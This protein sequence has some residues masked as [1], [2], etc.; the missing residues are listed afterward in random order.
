MKKSQ[1]F[2]LLLLMLLLS[3]NKIKN[4]IG[5]SN[6]YYDTVKLK[7]KQYLVFTKKDSINHGEAKYIKPIG[8]WET[9]LYLQ[10][11]LIISITYAGDSIKRVKYYY[12]YRPNTIDTLTLV[13]VL[14]ESKDNLKKIQKECYYIEDY[15][16]DTINYG[17][18]YEVEIIGNNGR[19]KDFGMKL[20]LGDID[21]NYHFIG[22]TASFSSDSN[23]LKYS[24]NDYKQGIN[25][26]T[27][28]LYY[29]KEGKDITGEALLKD[30]GLPI[31]YY[32]QF[33]VEGKEE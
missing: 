15:S 19:D 21:S 27:G 14:T 22:D 28:K 25:L 2:F 13:G 20:V 23:I 9:R 26:I 6:L 11:K 1:L 8:V 10:D 33:Y 31:I 24:Y 7:E 12:Y 16:K 18:E 30:I 29:I 5:K 17:E 32:K 3:C 4:N